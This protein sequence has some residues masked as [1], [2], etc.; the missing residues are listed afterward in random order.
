MELIG[1]HE[2]E[3]CSFHVKKKKNV[4][5]FDCI[6]HASNSLEKRPGSYEA[7]TEHIFSINSDWIC[8]LN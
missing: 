1:M 8:E 5:N 2:M 4:N 6:R 3:F 7:K